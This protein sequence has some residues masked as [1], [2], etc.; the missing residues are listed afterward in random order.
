[1]KHQNKARASE[2]IFR[3]L[4]TSKDIGVWGLD[5]LGIGVWLKWSYLLLLLGRLYHLWA[6]TESLPWM[7][8][9]IQALQPLNLQVCTKWYTRNGRNHHSLVLCNHILCWHL[10]IYILHSL[11]WKGWHFFWQTNPFLFG[12]LGFLERIIFERTD[13]VTSFLHWLL[14][15]LFS[16]LVSGI[17]QIYCRVY[18]RE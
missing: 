3:W 10:R 9:R 18:V 17:F 2:Q 12:G 14:L 1:M 15:L 11:H 13:T 5:F 4:L 6:L 16:S 8:E 7:N